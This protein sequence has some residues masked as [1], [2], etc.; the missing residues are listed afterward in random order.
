MLYWP[1][2]YVFSVTF[3]FQV[4]MDLSPWRMIEISDVCFKVC[5]AHLKASG[6]RRF[7]S[8]IFEEIADCDCG[9]TE[10]EYRFWLYHF[11]GP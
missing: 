10:E 3:L 7:W 11:E 2:Q 6:G 4:F 9:L 8:F 1:L 5:N